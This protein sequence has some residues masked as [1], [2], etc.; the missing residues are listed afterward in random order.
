MSIL[1]VTILLGLN[2]FHDS[3]V[4]GAGLLKVPDDEFALDDAD[5]D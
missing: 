1:E 2:A 5:L 3:E 4:K